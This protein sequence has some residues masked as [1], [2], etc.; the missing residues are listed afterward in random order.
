[1]S[2]VEDD[3]RGAVAAV[4]V[5]VRDVDVDENV[6]S[7]EDDGDHAVVVEGRVVVTSIT[8]GRNAR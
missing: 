8:N 4:K 6:A 3:G 5:L 2:V 1:V 7:P